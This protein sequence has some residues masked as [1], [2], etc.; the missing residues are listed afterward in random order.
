VIRLLSIRV[1]PPFW[2]PHLQCHFLP[3]VL[4]CLNLPIHTER[5]NPTR[6]QSFS[7]AFNNTLTQDSLD[8]Q[9]A[10]TK[11]SQCS[12]RVLSSSPDVLGHVNKVSSV[13]RPWSVSEWKFGG[14]KVKAED[15]GDHLWLIFSVPSGGT[16]IHSKDELTTG[17]IVGSLKTYRMHMPLPSTGCVSYFPHSCDEYPPRSNPREEACIRSPRLSGDGSSGQRR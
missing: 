13:Q 12:A 17:G 1:Q 14:M 7:L 3:C 9:V 15:T 8:M 6:S 5:P 10:L 11:G 16:I 2:E 4:Q